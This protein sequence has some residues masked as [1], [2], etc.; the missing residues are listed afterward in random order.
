MCICINCRH[1]IKCKTYK[2][3]QNQHQLVNKEKH[4]VYFHPLDTIISVNINKDK[5]NI[6]L[7]WDLKECSSFTEKPNSWAM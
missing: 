6:L 1:L 2:F 4:H 3:I 7:D 5:K